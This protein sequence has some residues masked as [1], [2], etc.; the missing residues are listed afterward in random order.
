MRPNLRFWVWIPAGRLPAHLAGLS[1]RRL[2][3]YSATVAL[4]SVS[5]GSELK[6]YGGRCWYQPDRNDT[7]Q[8]QITPRADSS[9]ASTRG[10]G[11][12]GLPS[13]TANALIS[14]AILTA[15]AFIASSS[16]GWPEAV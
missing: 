1:L 3:M 6:M 8:M 5:V 12:A 16:V 15:S 4:Y 10:I 7:V 14:L 11:C 9:S 13:M 2:P